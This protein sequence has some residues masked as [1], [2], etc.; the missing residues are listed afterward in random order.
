M[1]W[2]NTEVN[3][4]AGTPFVG[5]DVKMKAGPGGNRGVVTAWD[6]MRRKAVW[7]IKEDLPV[8]SGALVTAGDIVFYGTMEGWF[9]AA[10][11][12]TGAVKWQFKTGSGIIGQPVAYKGPDGREYVAILSGV[13]GWAG[14]LVA[15]NLDP[16]DP[17]GALG[18]VGAVPDLKQKTTPGGTLYVFALPQPS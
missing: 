12:H 8:W 16:Q 9:K 10:D 2:E 4:I 7:E 5:A 6:P 3:Y 13:G 14:A 11:A 1:D 17:T 15:G 18:F